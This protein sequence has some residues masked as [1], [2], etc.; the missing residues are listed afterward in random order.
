[1][2]CLSQQPGDNI[3]KL[4]SGLQTGDIRHKKHEYHPALGKNQMRP[5]QHIDTAGMVF[6][7]VNESH[8]F[9]N[10]FLLNKL[11]ILGKKWMEPPLTTFACFIMFL[12]FGTMLGNIP[13]GTIK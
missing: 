9:P 1:M 8:N 11:S 2:G 13:T 3:L 7:H 10:V 6:S 12:K 5:G 4:Q